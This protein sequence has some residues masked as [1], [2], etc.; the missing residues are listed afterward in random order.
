MIDVYTTDEN[1]IYF[2]DMIDL[3]CVEKMT[4]R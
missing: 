2:A 3:S 1:V 4:I